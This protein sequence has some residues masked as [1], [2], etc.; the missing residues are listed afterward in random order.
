MFRAGFLAVAAG[1]VAGMGL[2]GV[3]QAGNTVHV[4]AAASLTDAMNALVS[5]YEKSHPD[6]D[7]VPVYAS[8]S[9]VARQIANGA[10]AQIYVSAN[11]QWMDWLGQ[12]DMTLTDRRDLLRNSLVLI[13][14]QASTLDDVTPDA[15]HPLVD[16]LQPGERISVGDPDHVPA[17]IYARQ[18]LQ[19]EGQ[20]DT[21]KPRLA[22]A[23]DVRAALALVERGETP[24]GIVYATDAMASSRVRLLGTF[25]ADSHPAITYPMA[26]I[27]TPDATTEAFYQWLQGDAAGQVLADYGFSP[28]GDDDR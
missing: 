7:V 1:L 20:W 23:S 5:Q 4:Y 28:A 25:P 9:T 15:A 13:A 19:T 24:L 11:E 12:Q 26:E 14:P 27:G 21:L 10:P 18:A 16:Y 17:G 2:A 6:V 22:R 3:A 8:S